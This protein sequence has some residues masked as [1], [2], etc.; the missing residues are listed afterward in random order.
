VSETEK[1]P[2]EATRE[3]AAVTPEAAK[4]PEK[5]DVEVSKWIKNFAALVTTI[6]VLVG[7]WTT[8]YQIQLKVKADQAAAEAK[9]KADQKA[10]QDRLNTEKEISHNNQ[11]A[12]EAKR[13]ALTK[14]IQDQVDARKDQAAQ[15]HVDI[16]Q[17]TKVLADS[18]AK[19]EAERLSAVI[20]HLFNAK[21]TSA[22]GDLA[23]LFEYVSRDETSKEIV[24][25]VVLARLENP[26]SPEEIDMG[27]R[28]LETIG[29]SALDAT[30][31][32][33][34]DARR[35]YDECLVSRYYTDV[36]RLRKIEVKPGDSD[37]IY[38]G[39]GY[40]LNVDK[41]AK[42]DVVANTPLDASYVFP[43]ISEFAHRGTN[44][45]FD[46]GPAETSAKCTQ[47]LAAEIITRSNLALMVQFRLAV[48]HRNDPRSSVVDLSK[49]YLT[50]EIFGAGEGVTMFG[51][52]IDQAYIGMDKTWR[53][54][55]QANGGR[56]VP[57]VFLDA[58]S[59][60][61][62]G[63]IGQGAGFF[64]KFSFCLEHMQ[65]VM[66]NEKNRR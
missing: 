11:L 30:A 28:V 25:N 27:F 5:P 35:R 63:S 22:E 3:A 19:T 26:R 33:N 52:N 64:E 47:P 48:I 55:I 9:S 46:V 50:P 20:N 61:E 8:F 62:P 13:D 29:P 6:A 16:E 43:T 32:A 60:M 14:Q 42:E 49:T 44:P 57:A 17:A 37:V 39:N 31:Q 58:I 45:Y 10:E 21:E 2:P 4:Q 23:A 7:L 36:A 65:N 41:L 15:H 24:K 12:E 38:T 66:T 40:A 18:D 51:R 53:V 34:R 59:T 54:M 1:D 56:K